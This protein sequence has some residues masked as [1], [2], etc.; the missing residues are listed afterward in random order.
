LGQGSKASGRYGCDELWFQND[1]LGKE[2]DA[3]WTRRL[4]KRTLFL[5]LIFSSII[6]KTEFYG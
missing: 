1:V 6:E 5:S 2:L 4:F 3:L